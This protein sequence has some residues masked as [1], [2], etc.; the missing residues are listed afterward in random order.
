MPRSAVLHLP[1]ASEVGRVDTYCD[2]IDVDQAPRR[3]TVPPPRGPRRFQAPCR[4]PDPAPTAT[5]S[6]LSFLSS[7][8]YFFLL[9]LPR[10]GENRFIDLIFNIKRD[11]GVAA[12]R[13]P[14][15]GVTRDDSWSL[16]RPFLEVYF[17]FFSSRRR[18]TRSC[19]VSW[20]RRCV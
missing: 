7:S 14:S 17:F 11:V 10:S 4:P 16:I 3:G 1:G 19:L 15:W 20:A 8:N 9:F 12:I 13:P 6:S 2:D 18:H 5:T